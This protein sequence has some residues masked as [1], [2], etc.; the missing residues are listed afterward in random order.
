MRIDIY[1]LAVVLGIIHSIQFIIFLIEYYYHKSYKGPGWWLLWSGT[2][3]MGF[4]FLFARQIKAVEYIS[5]LG[6]N[7]MLILAS[8][9]IYIGIMRFLGKRERRNLLVFIFFGFIIPFTYFVFWE[10]NIHIRTILIWLTLFIIATISGYD[11]YLYKNKSVEI[12]AKICILVFWGHGIFAAS[13]VILLLTGS[14]INYVASDQFINTSTYFEIVIITIFWTYALIMMINQ[15]L[16]SEMKHAKDHFEAIFNT[17]PDAIFITS[18]SEGSITNAND[19]FYELSGYRLEESL[20]K[21]TSDLKLWIDSERRDN[22]LSMIRD[23]GYCF[24]YEAAFKCED[25]KKITGL[26]SG[27]SI[28]LNDKLQLISIIRDISER[29]RREELTKIQNEQL[30]EINNEKDKFFSIIAHDLRSP[31]STFLG[32]TEIMAEK[33]PSL[34]T[35]EILLLAAQMRDSARNLLG[36][37][38]NLLQWSLVKRG[39]AKFNPKQIELYS[40]IHEC[41]LTYLGAS[42]KKQITLLLKVSENEMVY[43]DQNM[44]RSLIRNILSNAIKFTPD[45]GSITISSETLP[46]NNC[47]ISIRDTGIGISQEMQKLLFKMDTNT[48]RRGTN[49]EL[50]TGLGLLLC[51][52]FVSM[53]QGEIWVESEEGVGSAFYFKLPPSKSA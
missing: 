49:G 17:T 53:H 4:I 45:G 14:E 24:D 2:S 39:L 5:I 42:Q 35:N 15:R 27:R 30:Q 38:E 48:S 3:A 51:K 1:T 26:V 10:D 12:A 25:G 11:L 9:F 8:I 47:V 52:E 46:D 50:S 20:G 21:T 29:K 32:L 36:L 33:L 37:L 34:P 28:N 16:T 22:Y 13:K 19:K 43:A 18:L 7:L 31:F 40:E 41:V 23:Q 6:Q 44:L